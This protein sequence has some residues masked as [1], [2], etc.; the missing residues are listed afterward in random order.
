VNVLVVFEGELVVPDSAL[1]ADLNEP[2]SLVIVQC[3][4]KSNLSDFKL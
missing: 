3:S 2:I 1:A 4:L